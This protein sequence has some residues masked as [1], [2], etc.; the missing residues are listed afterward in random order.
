MSF[1][2]LV[3]ISCSA[4]MC[5]CPA[6]LLLFSAIFWVGFSASSGGHVSC[7]KSRGTGLGFVSLGWI[8]LSGFVYGHL[9]SVGFERGV[10]MKLA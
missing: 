3:Y 4:S 7:C 1:G 5:P 9:L 6:M 10:L 2:T 8:L